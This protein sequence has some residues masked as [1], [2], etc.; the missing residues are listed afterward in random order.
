MEL[1]NRLSQ[2][3]TP[4]WES[5]CAKRMVGVSMGI[6]VGWMKCDGPVVAQRR[7]LHGGIGSLFPLRAIVGSITPQGRLDT[8]LTDA[9]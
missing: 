4:R 3:V 6:G 8:S 2:G 1:S 5:C 9:R 7:R